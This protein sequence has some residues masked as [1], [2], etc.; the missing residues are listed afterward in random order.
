MSALLDFLDYYTRTYEIPRAKCIAYKN[1]EKIFE[2]TGG[3]DADDGKN[4]YRMYSVTKVV[5]CAAALK[6]IEEG[7]MHLTDPLYM[8]YPEFKNINVRKR[9]ESGRG[10]ELCEAENPILIKHL[11]TMTAGF[12]YNI[13]SVAIRKL[14]KETGGRFPTQSII[15]ALSSQPL[16]FEPGTHWK[17]SLCHDVLGAL[18]ERIS[19]K[20]LDLY[21]KE[22]VFDPL[23]M[24]NSTF[25]C[26][27]ETEE[28]LVPEWRFDP[29]SLQFFPS[30][31]NEHVLGSEYVSGGASL[32]S[33]PEDMIVFADM[34]ASGGRGVLMPQTVELM[35]TNQL[36]TGLLKDIALATS[37]GGY[38]YGLGV[39]TMVSPIAADS[40]SP[41]GEFGWGGASGSYILS[42]TE[43]GISL[44]YAQNLLG[45]N[46]SH[47]HRLRNALYSDLA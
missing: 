44:Y 34:L 35:K 45:A 5:M 40:L 19:G 23:G 1:G 41:V 46:L 4:T 9:D 27:S 6:L 2:Y 29:Q 3:T 28:K 10:F 33:T 12:D 42:D 21:V 26:D 17:Y 22:N 13:H 25:F 8:Y 32:V 39:R 15:A 43:N 11:F 37:H 18:C 24:E 16:D 38:G 14:V 36:E 47:Y 31:G 20:P 30:A 7:K